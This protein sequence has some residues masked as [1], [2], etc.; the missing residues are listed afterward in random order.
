[1]LITE[2]KRMLNRMVLMKAHVLLAVFILPVAIMFFVTGAL[3]TWGIKGNS[4]TVVQKIVLQQP[5]QEQLGSLVILVE[6]AFKKQ[7]I[8]VPTGQAKPH[9]ARNQ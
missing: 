1:M 2:K 5:L 7:E 4:D 9:P 3:Y 8:A 6:E